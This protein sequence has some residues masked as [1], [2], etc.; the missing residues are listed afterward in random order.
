MKHPRRKRSAK[1]SEAVFRGKKSFYS[2]EVYPLTAQIADTPAVFIFSRRQTDKF[3]SGHHATIC[4]GETD[5]I[6][7]EIKRH[8]RARCV[9]RTAANVVCVLKE[10][11][12]SA[13]DGV[14]EDLTAVRSFSCVRSADEPNIMPRPPIIAP[15]PRRVYAAPKSNE[16]DSLATSANG[17]EKPANVPKRAVA[18][19]KSKERTKSTARKRKTVHASK[20][21]VKDGNSTRRKSVASRSSGR[22]A[23]VAG[24]GS[25]G[26]RP[27]AKVATATTPKA[28]AGRHT[29][30]DAELTNS[31]RPKATKSKSAAKPK[32]APDRKAGGTK[33]ITSAGSEKRSGGI[34]AKRP[35]KS[36]ARKKSTAGTGAGIPG[37]VDRDGGQRRLSE[38][39]RPA[40]R[41]A[42]TGIARNSRSRQKAAA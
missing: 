19:A 23:A 11:S 12:E 21:S 26:A 13:R 20:R 32:N 35:A 27:S 10:V 17:T 41:R 4:I 1:I 25:R 38:P 6:L 28:I 3:G 33:R 15:A 36:A 14:I 7:A 29:I 2:F 31:V 9:K 22:A 30:A 34:E 42:K 5:S 39:K 18:K 40:A 24:N 16:A 8:K 37:G